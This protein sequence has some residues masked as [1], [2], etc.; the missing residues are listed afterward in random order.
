M[1]DKKQE[2]AAL[3]AKMVAEQKARQRRATI[4]K[5]AA[6]IGAMAVIVA[7]GIV[8]GIKGGGG[9]SDD[10]A[11]KLVPAGESKYGMTVGD[12]NA[13][14][15]VIM[16]EDF[17]CPYC[18]AFEDAGHEELQ[19]LADEGKVYLDYRPFHL[20]SPD[21][22]TQAAN[23]FFVVWKE[24]GEDVALKFHNLL[25][26]T[27]NQ[28]SEE[29]STIQDGSYPAAQHLIDLAVQAG[30]DKGDIETK[31]ENGED[32][33]MVTKATQEAYDTG[34]NGTPTVYLDGKEFTQYTNMS[35]L[36]ANLIKAVS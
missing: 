4:L 20:L 14:H 29:D 9:G 33:S 3:A 31:I 5:V 18:Q 21:Y 24:S 1:A 15:Q 28:P 6:V 25:Y 11:T 7:V 16:Y 13:P 19:K 30:A 36:A 35:D 8:V 12:K 22:S 10:T 26:Q 2:R 23:A 27:G 34:L 32:D 17:L